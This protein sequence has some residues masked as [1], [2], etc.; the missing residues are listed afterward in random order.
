MVISC[1]I[2][3]KI[4]FIVFYSEINFDV[5]LIAVDSISVHARCMED[6]FVC[7]DRYCSCSIS[8]RVN[9]FVSRWLRMLFVHS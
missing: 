7:D 5:S 9:D 2:Y 1:G 4:S 3:D 6:D 8:R